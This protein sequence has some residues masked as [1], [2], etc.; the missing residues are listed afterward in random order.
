MKKT[1][2]GI[3]CLLIVVGLFSY[4]GMKMPETVFFMCDVM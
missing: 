1:V 4:M 2:S 3:I